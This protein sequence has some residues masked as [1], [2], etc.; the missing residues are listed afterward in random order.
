MSGSSL[1]PGITVLDQ[2]LC[3]FFIQLVLI[4]IVCR[5]LSIVGQYFHQPSVVFEIVG[6][7]ILGPSALGKYEPYT[8]ALLP[9][10]SLETLSIFANFGLQLYLFLVGLELDLGIL[11]EHSK[12]TAIIALVGMIVPFGIG[13]AVSVLLYSFYAPETVNGTHASFITFAVFIGTAMAVTAL[14]VLARI[15]KEQ[16]LLYTKPGFI[17]LG[18]AVITD[19]LAWILLVVAISLANA[20]NTAIAAWTFLG[21]TSY[22]VVVFTLGRWLLQLLVHKVENWNAGEA[23]V[24]NL[25]T[26]SIILLFL[27]AS[28]VAQLG[29]DPIVGSFLFG[30][31]IPR[32][33]HL[34]RCCVSTL[35]NFVLVLLLPLFFA[36]SGLK[37]DITVLQPYPDLL[38]LLL[39][40]A[41]AMLGKFLGAGLAALACGMS[42]RESSVVAVLMNTR[43]LVE[44]IVL[45]IGL[46]FHVLDSRAF[47]ILVLMCLF[48]TFITCPLLQC[49][50]PLR[51]RKFV[52]A[53]APGELLDEELG[54]DRGADHLH[55]HDSGDSSVYGYHRD[56]ARCGFDRERMGE[57]SGSSSRYAVGQD[58]SA[59]EVKDGTDWTATH[60]AD[61]ATDRGGSGGGE[62]WD[63]RE[64]TQAG[65]VVGGDLVH[66]RTAG[67]LELELVPV[68]ERGGTSNTLTEGSLPV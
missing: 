66:P 49:L 26:L 44:L 53:P 7:I 14:P 47:S 32:H 64:L 23:T 4:L 3:L 42:V 50:Y 11:K 25:L 67:E 68:R 57:R 41:C 12:A 13:L 1:F 48:T 28:I 30:A 46:K 51:V 34:H 2:P 38:I 62:E 59:E 21:I 31:V 54:V 63:E 40:I 60:T 27:S 39:V 43:G 6:G 45:N 19:A 65:Q 8:Q 20:K 55:S 5:S 16:K 61:R 35:E 9:A 56:G 52:H 15:L 10:Y 22:A 36:V 37:T 17:A 29:I 24:N 33:T 58:G 18:A